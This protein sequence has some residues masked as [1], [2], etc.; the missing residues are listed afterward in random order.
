MKTS[1]LLGSALGVFLLAG[2]AS[3]TTTDLTATLDKTQETP[4][5]TS[6]ATGT[7]TLKY[8]DTTHKL[9]GT[10]TYSGASGA[11]TAGHVHSGECGEAGPVAVTLGTALTSPITIDVDIP[12]ADQDNV[13]CGGLYLNLHTDANPNGEIRGQ[14]LKTG[15]AACTG[16]KAATPSCGAPDAGSSS[17]N[18]D[19]DAGSSGD[20]TSG[21]TSGTS[22]TSST[23]SSGSSSSSGCSTTGSSGAGTAASLA[24]GVGL[25]VAAISRNRK[26]KS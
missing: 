26:K 21:G 25:V 11:V 16:T 12:D 7:A 5:T 19:T 24:I 1:L 18:T 8:D 20:T 3:A 13:L 4:A 10:L 17:G 14:I 6:A 22:G 2:T 15:A 23:S 9:T